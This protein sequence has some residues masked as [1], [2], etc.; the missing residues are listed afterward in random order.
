MI[1]FTEKLRV[2]QIN[3]S[4][5]IIDIF[6]IE[7]KTYRNIVLRTHFNELQQNLYLIPWCSHLSWLL[8]LSTSTCVSLKY[9]CI[10]H[11]LYIQQEASCKKAHRSAPS[12]VESMRHV[13]GIIRIRIL[14]LIY[15]ILIQTHINLG[16]ENVI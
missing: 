2:N 5:C 9:L 16:L 7:N 13:I 12:C 6:F 4:A 10:T 11:V 15:G 3:E 1:F 14:H 8:R